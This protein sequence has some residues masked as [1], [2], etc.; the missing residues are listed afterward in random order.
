[1]SLTD[2]VSC[3]IVK[4]ISV[5]GRSGNFGHA[6]RPG[7]RGGSAPKGNRMTQPIVAKRPSGEAWLE[8]LIA[9]SDAAMLDSACESIFGDPKMW[10]RLP[11]AYEVDYNGIT[12]R[13]VRVRAINEYGWTDILV[14]GEIYDP[15]GKRIGSFSR[16]ILPGPRVE[17]DSLRL[18]REYQGLG[19]GTYFYKHSEDVYRT[20]GIKSVDLHANIDVGGYTWARL[21]FDWLDESQIRDIHARFDTLW[22]EKQ[23]KAPNPRPFFEHAWELAAYEHRDETGQV[24]F[25]GKDVL[26]GSSWYGSKSLTPGSLGDKIGQIYYREKGLVD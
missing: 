16:A 6:G 12:S 19:F 26:L 15:N 7:L 14:Q 9:S 8:T 3:R 23:V 21:G 25:R 20:M 4:L 22:K 13:I 11:E 24:D 1:M 17:H 10:H 18:S 5:R 2:L